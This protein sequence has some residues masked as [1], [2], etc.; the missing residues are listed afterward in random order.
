MYRVSGPRV[1]PQS[2]SSVCGAGGGGGDSRARCKIREKGK[3]EKGRFHRGAKAI[4][5]CVVMGGAR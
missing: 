5:C 1:V 3:E 2:S 4:V